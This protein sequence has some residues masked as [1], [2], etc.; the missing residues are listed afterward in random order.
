MLLIIFL[1]FQ[2]DR[3]LFFVFFSRD[4]V[5]GSPDRV[6]KTPAL[7]K[8]HISISIQLERESEMLYI[9]SNCRAGQLVPLCNSCRTL[10]LDRECR[11]QCCQEKINGPQTTFAE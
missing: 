9:Y 2:A 8:L 7:Q 6:T 4:H 5:A 1:Y 10:R 11:D 3:F